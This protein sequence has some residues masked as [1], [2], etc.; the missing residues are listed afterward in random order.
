LS[1]QVDSLKSVGSAQKDAIEV[2]SCR[3]EKTEKI[4][5][6]YNTLL[7][8]LPGEPDNCKKITSATKDEVI[9]QLQSQMLKQSKKQRMQSVRLKK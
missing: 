4:G 5:G 8:K 2:V 7:A 1:R 9:L 6:I 3:I